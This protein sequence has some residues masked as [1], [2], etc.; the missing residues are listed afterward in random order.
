MPRI[1]AVAGFAGSGKTTAIDF[2]EADGIGYRA[3]IGKFVTEQVVARG[4]SLTPANER[5]VRMALREEEGP[6]CLASLAEPTIRALLNDGKDV[7]ID[8]IA[9]IH[10][11]DA[12]RKHDCSDFV[13]VAVKASFAS[14]V[15]RLSKRSIKPLGEE[16]LRRRDT[17]ESEELGASSVMEAATVVLIN[18]GPLSAFHAAL[19]ELFRD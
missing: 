2:L 6:A 19:N 12:Y 5:T 3:Y 13:L 16:D 1:I 4:L 7:L 18:D 14:R 10:E 17:L 15:A 8:A 9:S 11:L